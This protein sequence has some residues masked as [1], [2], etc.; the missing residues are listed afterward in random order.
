MSRPIPQGSVQKEGGWQSSDRSWTRCKG[1][2]AAVR[3]YHVR[4]AKRGTKGRGGDM[5]KRVA[6][7]CRIPGQSTKGMARGILG[8]RI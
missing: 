8:T 3:S 1:C 6:T 2:K 5:L 4:R 7:S